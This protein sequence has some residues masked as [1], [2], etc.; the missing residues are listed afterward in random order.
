MKIWAYAICWNEEVM[1]PYYLKHYEKFCEKIIIYD[2]MSTD[3][4][5][6][7]IKNHPLCE[8]RTYDTKNQ[9]RDDIYLNIKNNC[10]KEAKGK[11]DYVIVGDIDEFLYHKDLIGFLNKNKGKFTIF[12]P[13]G[14]E[15]ASLKFP[16]TKDQLYT[17]CKKGLFHDNQS[18]KIIFSPNA[19]TEMNWFAGCHHNPKQIA[20]GKTWKYSSE[21]PYKSELKLL[22]FKYIDIDYVTKRHNELSKRLSEIN[23][24]RGW[25]FHYSKGPLYVKETVERIYRTSKELNL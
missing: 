10:W 20:S 16:H 9:I 18:K 21:D 19:V 25:G 17:V 13:A 6:N 11:A 4:S 12:Q 3:N 23:R 14:F 8:L 22:H 7:I 2:N 1:L 24:K 5:R 15:M